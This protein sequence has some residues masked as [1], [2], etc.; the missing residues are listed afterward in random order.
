MSLSFKRYPFSVF[1]LLSLSLSPLFG[2][3]IFAPFISKLEAKVQNNS[4]ILSWSDAEAAIDHYE[5]YRSRSSFNRSSFDSSTLVS[6][7]SAGQETYRDYPPTTDQ[8]YYAVL[9]AK[10]D[11]SVY[12]LFIPY[13]NV[14]VTGLAVESTSSPEKLATKVTSITASVK[15][16]AVYLDFDRTKPDRPIIVYRSTSPLRSMEDLVDATSLSSQNSSENRVVDYPLPGISYYY[17]VFDAKTAM[18]GSYEFL[19]GENT[20]GEAVEVPLEQSTLISLESRTKRSTPLPYLLLSESV[21]TGEELSVSLSFDRM[22]K[23]KTLEPETVKAFDAL[24]RK[25]STASQKDKPSPELL[26]ADRVSS[27]MRGAEYRLSKM[28]QDGFSSKQ[29]PALERRLEE[30]LLIDHGDYIEHRAHFY[31]GQALF[32]QQDYRRSFLE[33]TLA[34]DD[35]RREVDRWLN[36]LYDRISGS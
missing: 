5:V 20:T 27:Q 10:D 34:R 4:V 33:F 1:L 15:G 11:D 35:Y 18:A 13:R 22:G 7:V 25:G 21:L 16:D 3:E 2:E 23:A 9:A 6:R 14:T 12:E 8:Y 30:F 26:P 17:A 31:L 32:F 29:W 19:V 36:F 28:V 24:L